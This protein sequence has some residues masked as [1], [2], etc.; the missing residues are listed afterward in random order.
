MFETR[1]KVKD[2]FE[3]CGDD[4]GDAYIETMIDPSIRFDDR[5]ANEK[6]WVHKPFLRRVNQAVLCFHQE[7]SHLL[8]GYWISFSTLHQLKHGMA[9]TFSSFNSM[10]A[11]AARR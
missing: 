7:H 6:G 2:S 10:S 5:T 8:R 1:V 9:A 3:M 4:A 11:R